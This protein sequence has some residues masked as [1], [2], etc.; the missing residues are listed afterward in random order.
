MTTHVFSPFLSKRNSIFHGLRADRG[1]LFVLP[2]LELKTDQANLTTGNSNS[3]R[4]SSSSSSSGNNRLTGGRLR[5][6]FPV[7]GTGA[8]RLFRVFLFFFPP[9][10]YLIL[11]LI[12]ERTKCDATYL[13]TIANLLHD[14]RAAL[15]ISRRSRILTRPEKRTNALSILSEILR[16]FFYASIDY[17]R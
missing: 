16:P 15:V 6:C 2:V 8:E 13:R 14:L 5:R 1:S 10:D 7:P 12:A 3:G 9:E 17:A 11:A 4:S